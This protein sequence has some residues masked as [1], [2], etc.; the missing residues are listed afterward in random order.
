MEGVWY[1][2]ISHG[3]LQVSNMLVWLLAGLV[4]VWL[5]WSCP[6]VEMMS[7]LLALCEGNPPVTPVVPPHKGPIVWS[8]DVSLNKLS[9]K[10]SSWLW[11]EIPWGTYDITVMWHSGAMMG[12]CWLGLCYVERL[13]LW[14]SDVGLI[15][16]I[17]RGV[18]L[19]WLNGGLMICV[20]LSLISNIRSWLLIPYPF[21]SINFK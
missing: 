15:C 7:T 16:I 8:F 14:W 21:T 2:A 6:D 4:C 13:W 20:R 3:I 11:F 18:E 9:N 17:L 12:W 5:K 10:Q 19:W 1:T